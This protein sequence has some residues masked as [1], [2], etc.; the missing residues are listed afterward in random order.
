MKQGEFIIDI[1]L[2]MRC[3]A[4]WR[5]EKLRAYNKLRKKLIDFA[6]DMG[7]HIIVYQ[8]FETNDMVVSIN[9]SRGGHFL[10]AREMED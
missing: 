7:H 8:L 6:E 2:P 3:I 9:M 10:S 5:P 1:I 4:C